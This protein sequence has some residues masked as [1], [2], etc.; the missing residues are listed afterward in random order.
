[1]KKVNKI[2]SAV[3]AFSLAAAGSGAML[4]ESVNAYRLE[5]GEKVYSIIGDRIMYSVEK[6]FDQTIVTFEASIRMPKG[7]A[8][9]IEGGVIFGNYWNRN[10]EFGDAC[11]FSVGKNGNFRVGWGA[12][13]SGSGTAQTF[14]YDHTFTGYD[15]RTGEWTHIA[16]VYD[17]ANN[18]MHYYVNGQL[19]E[20][21]TPD[22]KIPY[23]AV[24]TMKFGVGCDWNHWL[25]NKTPFYGDIRQITAYSTAL[26]Q[27]QISDDMSD[28]QITS[29]ERKDMG[30]MGNWYFSEFWGQDKTIY[31]TADNGPDCIRYTY[32]TYVP[33]ENPGMD[34][35]WDYS[36]AV[37]PD[38]QAMTHYKHDNLNG[39]TEWLV[40]NKEEYNI[41]F[42]S[43]LG[44]LGECQY[45]DESK[46][47]H[48]EEEWAFMANALHKLD[49]EIPYIPV[50]GNHDY[51]DWCRTNRNTTMF[52]KH[53]KY[54]D[55]KNLPGFGG[56]FK[57]GDMDNNY[58]LIKVSEDVEYLVFGLEYTPRYTVL[59]WMDRIISEH[60]N[61][62]VI[63]NSH[64]LVNPDGLFN[65]A[66]GTAN[67]DG[68]ANKHSVSSYTGWNT[69]DKIARKH[70]NMFMMYSGH[71]PSD[72]IV[73]RTDIGDN[74]NKVY[75]TLVDYQGAM[76][77]SKMNTF[78][79]VKVDEDTKMMSF[80]AYSP[81]MDACYNEQNQWTFSFADENNPAIGGV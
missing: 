53:F 62:R 60:P 52:D 19:N 42:V 78:L 45:A 21:H 29:A 43:Y 51:D 25:G 14:N 72:E 37:I 32:D 26:T 1:M 23:E 17:K 65:G 49:N 18:S 13:V 59:N 12:K 79:L 80:C 56:V 57:E 33:V 76:L 67:S 24:S 73:T 34:G 9:E 48:V 10:V 36:F 40:E 77:T 6:A 50:L 47:A 2:L 46:R 63:V 16:V 61:A 81:E 7:L 68:N 30:L 3:L 55:M 41:Q 58:S 66:E 27:A 44:D 11:N 15:L 8:D 54:D 70:A 31:N 64:C 22:T 75:S 35:G 4:T 38:I 28:T 39:L 20:T 74:G 69:W 5:N 71:I